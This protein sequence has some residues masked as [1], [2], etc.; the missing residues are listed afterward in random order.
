MF[1]MSKSVEWVVGLSSEQSVN[2]QSG[3]VMFGEYH[4]SR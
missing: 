4:S 3:G 2:Q 1:V